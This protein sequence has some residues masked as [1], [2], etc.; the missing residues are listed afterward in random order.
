MDITERESDCMR[1]LTLE[2]WGRIVGMFEQNQI[3]IR[4]SSPLGIISRR[5]AGTEERTHESNDES[6][7]KTMAARRSEHD[8]RAVLSMLR[9]VEQ[10]EAAEMMNEDEMNVVFDRNEF[11]CV[12]CYV[13]GDEYDDVE[14]VRF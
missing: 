13:E 9:L 11:Q 4:V 7:S 1:F 10:A 12:P 5:L 14:E 2:R 8:A 6:E 3:G